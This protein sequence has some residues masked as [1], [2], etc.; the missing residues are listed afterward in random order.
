[1]GFIKPFHRNFREFI[2][3]NNSG[4]SSWAYIVDRE[5]AQSPEHYTR[6]FILIQ[7]D[8]KKLFEYTVSTEK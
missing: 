7:N 3:D 6:A 4:Y 2:T 1:M 8:L 5:Y